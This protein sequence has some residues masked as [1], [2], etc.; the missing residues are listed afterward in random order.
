M[1]QNC[2]QRSKLQLQFAKS[3]CVA[4]DNLT[5]LRYDSCT[6]WYY[7]V[8]QL[9]L[10]SY[11]GLSRLTLRSRCNASNLTPSFSIILDEACQTIYIYMF[12]RI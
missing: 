6:S 4:F 10:I 11:Q 7:H 2:Q 5:W 1:C 3:P 9:F 8:L 12:V